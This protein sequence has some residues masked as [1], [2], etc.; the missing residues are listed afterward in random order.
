MTSFPVHNSRRRFAL[1]SCTVYFV[2]CS[3]IARTHYFTITEWLSTVTGPIATTCHFKGTLNIIKAYGFFCSL[4]LVWQGCSCTSSRRGLA[5]IILPGFNRFFGSKML[6]EIDHHLIALC[7]HHFLKK[8]SPDTAISM[9]T[10][11]RSFVL[12]YEFS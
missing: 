6:L 4:G 2:L 3:A 7:T 8:W 12:L 11:K 1:S 10:T 9:F 5:S